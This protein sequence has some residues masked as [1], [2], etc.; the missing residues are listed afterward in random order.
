ML[1]T[2]R[3]MVSL[4]WALTWAT[5]RKS[6]WQTVGYVVSLL[7]AVG[8]VITT[9]K[10]AYEVGDSA[11]MLG[12][13]PSAEQIQTYGEQLGD[14]V[15]VAGLCIALL[16][17]IIQIMLVGESSTL[18]P[19]RFELFG[20]P[21]KQ[22]SVGVL[23][24]TLSGVPAIA[25]VLALMFWAS[26]YR[27]FGA[28]VVLMGVVAAFLIVLSFVCI[29]K[30][31]VSLITTFIRSSAGKAT[32]YAI[33]MVIFIFAMQMPN[34]VISGWKPSFDAQNPAASL[35]SIVQVLHTPA[36]II[37]FTPFA[38][39][40]R[41]PF[42][43]LQGNWVGLLIRLLIITATL[44]ICFLIGLWSIHYERLHPMQVKSKAA[45]GNGLGM[46]ARTPDSVS[47]AVSARFATYL[48]RDPRQ[49]LTL[50]MPLLFMV[51]YGAMGINDPDMRVLIWLA[52]P[53]GAWFLPV[54]E[55]NGL[56]YDGRGWTM[57]V[58]AGIRGKD[59]RIG[60][61]RVFV[62]ISTVYLVILGIVCRVVAGDEYIDTMLGAVITLSSIGMMM[63]SLALSSVLSTVLMYPVPSIERPFSSP[64]GRAAAQMIAPFAFLVGS[65]AANILP[66]IGS[67]AVFVAGGPA[68]AWALI[69][70]W[71]ANGALMLW[72]GTWVAGKIIDA[73]QLRIMQTLESFAS[74]QK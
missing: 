17:L 66:I 2:I 5:M 15:T 42:D 57:Q 35:Q 32:M 36:Q 50:I 21:D 52:L 44:V 23:V 74:L 3:T 48:M 1:T 46:F 64:Q 29:S 59:D 72:L 63:A 61:A 18:S 70:L 22:L 20:I 55:A 38:A 47:G 41:L 67:I 7:I 43:V 62:S 4:R 60:R 53:L 28:G 14:I 34:I 26:A 19:Q 71:L 6:V 56:S 8:F 16:V 25:S 13:N 65:V 33:V 11:V 69:P 40:F 39:A 31:L 73:R 37:G 12:A 45:K 58:I 10:V 30:A 27:M 49:G 54:A 68:Y 51:I 24:A 9:A